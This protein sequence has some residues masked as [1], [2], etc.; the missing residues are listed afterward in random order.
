[1]SIGANLTVADATTPTPVNRTFVWN[2]QDPQGIS[3]WEDRSGGVPIGYWLIRLSLMRPKKRTVNLRGQPS[4]TGQYRCR[5]VVEQPV[6]ENVTNS[7]V[8]GISPAP[9]ISYKP[10][11]DGT[12]VLPERS[13]LI[14]RQHLAK[15]V[16]L[17]LQTALV[18][19]AIEDLDQPR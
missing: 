19:G 15:M 13:S 8:S 18:K 9:T 4:A 2:G 3:S 10:M 14:A 6:M 17:I 7:T 16:P 12:F 11:F 5:I 1:M